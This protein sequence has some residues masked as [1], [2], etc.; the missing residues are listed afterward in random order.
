MLYMSTKGLLCAAQ[1]VSYACSPNLSSHFKGFTSLGFTFL[2]WLA[3]KV[4]SEVVKQ[5]PAFATHRRLPVPLLGS[6]GSKKA[7]VY[8]SDHSSTVRQ[9]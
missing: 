5:L 2:G 4:Y 7:T 8:F 6:S 9:C 1:H 3:H